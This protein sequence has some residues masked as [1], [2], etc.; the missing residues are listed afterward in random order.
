MPSTGVA[1]AA[2]AIGAQRHE[3]VADVDVDMVHIAVS[4]GATRMI[5]G[6]QPLHDRCLTARCAKVDRHAVAMLRGLA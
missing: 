1:S 6:N 4:H 5:V 3:V 2:A